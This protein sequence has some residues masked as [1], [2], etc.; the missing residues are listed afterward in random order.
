[1]S[2]WGLTYNAGMLSEECGE[3]LSAVNKLRR[4]R[5]S[6]EEVITELADVSLI[7]TAF[8]MALGYDEFLEEKQNKLE[9][10]EKRLIEW[11]MKNGSKFVHI[12]DES[13]W[14]ANVPVRRR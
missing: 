13:Y 9:R 8:A 7:I 5:C 12:Q 6:K 3:L 14:R 1:M 11:R 10:L 4:K 2:N